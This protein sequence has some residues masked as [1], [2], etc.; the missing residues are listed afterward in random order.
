[1]KSLTILF[2]PSRIVKP[3]SIDNP[4]IKELLNIEHWA[5]MNNLHVHPAFLKALKKRNSLLTV[6]DGVIFVSYSIVILL[7]LIQQY[8]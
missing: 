6:L 7:I 1:M 8:W 5:L 2:L 4:S 3:H